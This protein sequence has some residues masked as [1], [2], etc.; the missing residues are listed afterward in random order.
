[1]LIDTDVF[2]FYRFSLYGNKFI[3]PC[4]RSF[5]LG[6]FDLFG[7]IEVF[8]SSGIWIVV[9]DDYEGFGNFGS[10]LMMP[11]SCLVRSFDLLDV[12]LF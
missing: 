8:V 9:P 3:I 4:D 6:I 2:P 1:M 11:K 7:A 10:P 12:F 5:I